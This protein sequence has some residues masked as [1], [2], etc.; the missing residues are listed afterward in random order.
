[1]KTRHLTL[2]TFIS[3][4]LLV[5]LLNACSQQQLDERSYPPLWQ[6]ENPQNGQQLWLY[7]TVHVLPYGKAPAIR[8]LQ[9]SAPSRLPT[10]LSKPEWVSPRLNR[11]LR[12]IDL[13]VMEL[14]Y[15]GQPKARNKA[16]Q[17]TRTTVN[18]YKNQKLM[19]LFNYL[20]EEE[21]QFV[22]EAGKQRGL[23]ASY[24]ESLSAPST[25]FMLSV[26]PRQDTGLDELRGVEDW[27]LSYA[28]IRHIPLAGLETP[29]LRLEAI[30]AAMQ[31]IDANQQHQ[32]VLDYLGASIEEAEAPLE[33]LELLYQMWRGAEIELIEQQRAAFAEYYPEIYEAFLGYRNRAW[34]PEIVDYLNDDDKVL[35]A[36]GQGHL[37]GPENI[38]DLLTEAGYI[39]TRV[40]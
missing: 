37:I 8:F 6:V 9:R 16:Q 24:L 15:S 11:L 33:D 21:K 13:L 19:P 40:Q 17:S 27:L 38:R 26:L 12:Q 36:V 23:Q 18:D 2:T 4:L 28:R 20:D 31:A 34:I 35:I 5:L 3:A 14:D 7:G 29:V 22:I 25:L 32:I 10:P 1:M 39:V 30:A